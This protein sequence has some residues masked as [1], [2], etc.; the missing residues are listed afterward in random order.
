MFR[1]TIRDVLWLMVVV[2]LACGWWMDRR[3][4]AALR[5]QANTS[6]YRRFMEER[7]NL[8]LQKLLAKEGRGFDVAPNG[9]VYLFDRTPEG[10]IA[11]D[12]FSAAEPK[13][14][15]RNNFGVCR[16]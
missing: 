6:D 12:P 2:G 13:D 8:E 16:S 3:Q 14:W 9:K 4:I 1:F 11:A 7:V 5:S 10:T 15:P